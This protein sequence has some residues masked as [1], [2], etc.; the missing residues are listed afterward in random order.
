ML[1]VVVLVAIV[2]VGY[3]AAANGAWTV[4]DIVEVGTALG[5]EIDGYDMNM[6]AVK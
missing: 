5:I 3:D 6:D 4:L 2:N 1:V